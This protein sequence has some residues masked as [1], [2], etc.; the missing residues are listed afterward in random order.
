MNGSGIDAYR[1]TNVITANPGNLVLMCYEGA[2]SSLKTAKEKYIS[3]EY[4]AKAE[5]VQKVQTI[6]G[7]LMKALD[8]EGGGRSGRKSGFPLQL[9]AAPHN[10]GRCKRGC[11]SF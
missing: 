5:A 8:F 7:E 1:Q 2:I 10:R 4:E 9:Y 3:K 11:K 6:I